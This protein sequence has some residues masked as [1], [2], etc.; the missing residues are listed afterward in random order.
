[1]DSSFKLVLKLVVMLLA[2]VSTLG[3]GVQ[4]NEV[5]QETGGGKV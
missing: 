3:G 5:V 2:I 4:G 1:M